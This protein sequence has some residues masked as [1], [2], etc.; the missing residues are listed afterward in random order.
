MNIFVT[1]NFLESESSSCTSS[2]SLILPDVQRVCLSDLSLQ[3]P[4]FT[5]HLDNFQPQDI[6]EEFGGT[7]GQNGKL[8]H[9]HDFVELR[10]TRYQVGIILLNWHT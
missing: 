7:I 6:V 9:A 5:I 4:P 1:L 3:S 10:S 2:L 8:V